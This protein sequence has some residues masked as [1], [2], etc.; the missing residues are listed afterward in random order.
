VLEGP[1]GLLG[2]A[3]PGLVIVLLSTIDVDEVEPLRRTAAAAGVRLLDCGV[4]GGPNSAEK[5]LVCLLG[6]DEATVSEVMPVLTDMSAKVLHMGEIGAGMRAK[7]SRNIVAFVQWRAMYETALLAEAAG[8]DLTKL[9]E[10]MELSHP[11]P[12]VMT[13]WL[14][15]G[16]VGPLPP[17]A[18]EERQRAEHVL[19]LLQKDVGAALALGERLGVDL[20]AA[21][22]THEQG[23][24][25]FGLGGAPST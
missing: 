20:P 4:T 6:G 7:V 21:R 12:A 8:V 14:R 11:S 16:T 18:T 15:R 13:A 1:E 3:H 9:V 23:A 25:I 24:P 2:A 17:E 22:L 10:A 5:G 19:R